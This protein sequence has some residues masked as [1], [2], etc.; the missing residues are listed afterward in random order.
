MRALVWTGDEL[1]VEQRPRPRIRPQE[2]LVEV[3]LA[4]VCST[5]L[6]IARGYMGFTGTLGHEFVGRVAEGPSDWLGRRIV[7]EINFGCGRCIECQTRSGRHCEKRRVLGILGA[8]GAFA[9]F[10]RVPVANLHA[11]PDRVAN[12]AAV[13]CEPV[14]AAFEILEQLSVRQGQRTTVLGDGKLGLLVA[15]VLSDAGARVLCVGRHSENLEILSSLGIETQLLDTWRGNH[16]HSAEIVIEATGHPEGFSLALD[17][18]QPRGTLVLKTTLAT[19]P[20]ID[21]APIVI[22]EIQVLGSR[23]GPFAP[24]LASLAEERIHVASLIAARLPL[25]RADEALTRAGEPGMRKVLIDC[26]DTAA[27]N[28]RSQD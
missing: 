22:D 21:L 14:A 5:D 12:E 7:S 9:E 6:E 19:S 27:V 2:A 10:V 11:V 3:E 18:V 13:F 16:R 17:A 25:A 26:T 15:Q 28:G 1:I 4:G 8:D 23:C 24:A 20:E